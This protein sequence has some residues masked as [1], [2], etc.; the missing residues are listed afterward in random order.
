MSEESF[1]SARLGLYYGFNCAHE[2]MQAVLAMEFLNTS[3]PRSKPAAQTPRTDPSVIERIPAASGLALPDCPLG[4]SGWV[5][6]VGSDSGTQ[7]RSSLS[8]VGVAAVVRPTEDHATI[9]MK[10]FANQNG[11]EE[12]E[13]VLY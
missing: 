11:Q 13:G 3:M 9:M 2:L 4:N 7:G 12:A 6:A 5:N 1:T 10:Y 8:N